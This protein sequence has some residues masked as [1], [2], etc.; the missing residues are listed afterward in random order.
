MV[1]VA[2]EFETL[3][4]YPDIRGHDMMSAVLLSLMEYLHDNNF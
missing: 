3:I 4:K 2:S 1:F